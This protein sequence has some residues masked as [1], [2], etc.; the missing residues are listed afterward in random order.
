MFFFVFFF[1][2]IFQCVLKYKNL[3]VLYLHGNGIE[4]IS[5]VD[6]LSSLPCLRSITLHGNPIEDS[7][8]GYRQ[9]VLSKLPLLKTFDFSGV[10]KSDR[11]CAEGWSQMYKGKK[12]KKQS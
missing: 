6:K 5:E 3:K 8:K 12:K 10:T 1:V 7:R 4:K 11:A 9:Y 2:L